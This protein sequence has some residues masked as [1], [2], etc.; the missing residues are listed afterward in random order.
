MWRVIVGSLAAVFIMIGQAWA[1]P[2]DV[3]TVGVLNC[4]GSCQA[5]TSL[6]AS[7]NV[8][9]DTGNPEGASFQDHYS[10]VLTGP[11]NMSGK[12]FALDFGSTFNVENLSFELFDPSMSSLGSFSVA[13]GSGSV[14]FT[15]FAFSSLVTGA[16]TLLV[17]GLIPQ[18]FE[19]GLYLLEGDLT[20]SA[21][22]SVPVPAAMWLFVSALFGMFSL[23]QMRK[24]SP[25]A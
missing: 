17:S 14:L 13:N 9:G 15:P 16:Y 7:R 4:G 5:G 22:S 8:P 18:A 25:H 6:I 20:Q 19:G 23:T 3:S 1:V 2:T 12:G 21:V 11:V 10:F 24:R